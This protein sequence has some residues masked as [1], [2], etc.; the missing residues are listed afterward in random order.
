MIG[1]SR[2]SAVIEV[3]ISLGL[4]AILITVIGNLISAVRRMETAQ[5]FR[6][7]AL[8]HTQET[9]EMITSLQNDLFACVS[10]TI[11]P[12]T[13][14]GSDG[15]TCALAIAYNSC[16]TNN[17]YGHTT[18]VAYY[19]L[20]GGQLVDGP[21]TVPSDTAFTRSIAI[22]NL[23]GDANRKK[24]T[25]EVLWQERGDDKSFQLATVLTGWSNVT[26]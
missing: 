12:G 15:Q 9:L 3:L 23:D 21:E 19:H 5:D 4:A 24:I 7:R 2:G 17:P 13:C 14:N 6:Q 25:V 20:A 1:K 16:W 10:P 18:P 26:P 22:E 8:T 11:G